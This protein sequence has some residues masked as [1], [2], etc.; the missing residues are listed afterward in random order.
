[1]SDDAY[2]EHRDDVYVVAGTRVS[3]DSIVYAF[4]SDQSAETTAQALPVLSLHER[5]PLSASGERHQAEQA[6]AK[7]R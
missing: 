1:M 5:Q 7:D 4:L 2:I 6:G 3:L